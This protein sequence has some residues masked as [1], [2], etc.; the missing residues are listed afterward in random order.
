VTAIKACVEASLEATYSGLWT[1][2]PLRAGD[3]DWLSAWVAWSFE[4]IIGVGLSK[5]DV[6]SDLWVHPSAQGFG[7][8]TSLLTE[9]ENEMA[10][11]VLLRLGSAA[12][13]PT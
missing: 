5:R 9:L 13:S 3:D 6:V 11:R 2:E 7:A 12:W 4:T 8:G 1:S 10:A